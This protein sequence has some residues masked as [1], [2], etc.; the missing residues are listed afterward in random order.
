MVLSRRLATID[1]STGSVE[2]STISTE[3]RKNY[4]GGRGMNM[5]LFSRAYPSASDPFSLQNPLIFGA[6]LL[7]GTLGC[8]GKPRC[9]KVCTPGAITL[10]K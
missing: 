3:L 10:P 5:V 8:G 7:T 9:I 4:L 2:I 6:G 1:L